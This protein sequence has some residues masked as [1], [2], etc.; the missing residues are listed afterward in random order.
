VSKTVLSREEVREVDRRAIEDYGLPGVVLMENA[1]RG[2][3]DLIDAGP[4]VICCGRGN[5]GGDGYVIARHLDNRRL[6]VEIIS[7]CGVDELGGD[8]RI[9]AEVAA[10]AG[11]S[12][13]VAREPEAWRGA[14]GRLRGA[15]W[16]VD[17][18][19][20]TGFQGALREPYGTAIRT[21]NSSLG[22]AARVLSVDVPSGLDVETGRP[23]AE[24]IQAHV[25]ATFV[26]MK[27]GFLEASARPSLGRVEVIDIGVPRGLL[28]SLGLV[29]E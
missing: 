12:I 26:A 7:V 10:R 4:V 19:L 3:A 9:H 13:T 11:I 6:P 5:N 23:A 20:G 29:Q 15:S 28:T 25:T 18:L 27:R 1:G 8:A 24:C 16:V 2:C 17:A 22:S 21:V 14:E